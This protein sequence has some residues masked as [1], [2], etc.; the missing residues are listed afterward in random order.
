MR[1]LL[2]LLFL[3]STQGYSANEE[4]SVNLFYFCLTFLVWVAGIGVIMEIHYRVHTLPKLQKGIYKFTFIDLFFWVL[5][6]VWTIGLILALKD[7]LLVYTI[8]T[9]KFILDFLNNIPTIYYFLSA[10][11]VLL[12]MIFIRLNANKKRED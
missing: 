9:L 12:V 7:L 5:R 2:I 4:E 11:I 6:I 3:F 10:I 1:Y 8:F